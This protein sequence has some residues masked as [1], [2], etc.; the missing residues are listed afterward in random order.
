[1]GW[2]QA[3]WK[4]PRLARPKMRKLEEDCVPGTKIAVPL[5]PCRMTDN[6]QNFH[7]INV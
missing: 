5:H 7:G 6:F 4:A 3:G 2:V 1:L